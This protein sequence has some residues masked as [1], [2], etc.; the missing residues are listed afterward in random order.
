MITP[1]EPD[2]SLRVVAA[3]YSQTPLD[4]SACAANLAEALAELK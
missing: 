1:I 2:N 4:E 3:L